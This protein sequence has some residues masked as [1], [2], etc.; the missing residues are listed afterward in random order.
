M[1]ELMITV[2]KVCKQNKIRDTMKNFMSLPNIVYNRM[3]RKYG[4]KI[5]AIKNM[6]ILLLAL[7]AAELFTEKYKMME[8]MMLTDCRSPHSEDLFV[9]LLLMGVLDPHL[10]NT[11]VVNYEEASLVRSLCEEHLTKLSTVYWEF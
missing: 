10:S 7:K 1:N 5:L 8:L 9:Y 3:S 11:K 4:V 6:K 2:K